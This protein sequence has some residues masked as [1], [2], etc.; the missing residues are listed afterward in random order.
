MIG[1]VVT[2]VRDASTGGIELGSIMNRVRIFRI[3]WFG[4]ALLFGQL[5]RHHPPPC[6]ESL[7]P[8]PWG[9]L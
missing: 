5:S 3:C 2:A 1:S 9:W 4:N 8:S 6:T 7:E